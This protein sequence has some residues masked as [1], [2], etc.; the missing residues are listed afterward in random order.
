MC[1]IFTGFR[2]LRGLGLGTAKGEKIK[3]KNGHFLI[4]NVSL[5]LQSF[6]GYCGTSRPAISLI[7]FSFSPYS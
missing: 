3:N 4:K 6:L 1:S 5:N 2:F 7:I